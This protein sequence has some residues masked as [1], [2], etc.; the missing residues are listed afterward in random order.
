MILRR[1][2]SLP[3]WS[4]GLRELEDARRDIERLFN[5]LTDFSGL[6]SV[7]VFPAIN[8]SEDAES[9]YVRAELPGIKADDLDIRMENDTLTIA[10]ERK[11][12][13][14][15]DGVSFHRREREWGAF[16]RSF[17]LPTRVDAGKV[18]ARYVDGILTV[19]LPKAAEARP[20]QIAVQAGA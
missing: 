9:V 8:L 15:A 19:T 6:R 10:G 11:P 7:G 12:P 14:E 18:K 3:T 16:R 4:T 20:K 13:T 2:P 17:S 1:L 5:T